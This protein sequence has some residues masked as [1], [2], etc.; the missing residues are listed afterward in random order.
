MAIAHQPFLEDFAREAEEIREK[1]TKDLLIAEKAEARSEKLAKAYKGLARGLHTLKGSAATLGLPEIARAAHELE[2]H[3]APLLKRQEPFPGAQADGFLKAIDGL[4]AAAQQAARPAPEVTPAQ[5]APQESVAAEPPA[6]SADG[7]EWRVGWKQ[8]APFTVEVERLR[9]SRIRLL[10]LRQRAAAMAGLQRDG[11]QASLLERALASEAASA[12]AMVEAL[13][14][15]L[16]DI[17]TVPAG[18]VI[19]PLQRTVRDLCRQSGKEARLS[20]VGGE[21]RVDRRILE[22][23]RGPLI[24]LVRNAVDHGIETPA[25]R[26]AGGKHGAGAIVV[27]VELQGNLVFLEMSDDGAGLDLKRV[28]E[29]AVAKG[30]LSAVEADRL[31]AQA[32]AALIFRSGFSTRSD[33]S[34][35]SGRGVGLDVVENEVRAL[36][37]RV[38]VSSVP[39]QGTRF[40]IMVPAKMGSAPFLRVRC[41]EHELA[42]PLLAVERIASV[43][44][45]QLRGK[46]EEAR[47]EHEG[48]I[49]K[50]RDL[51]GLLGLRQPIPFGD[52]QPLVFIRSEGR[53][54]AVLVDAILGE[55]E[56]TLTPL[57]AEL[58]A[59]PCYQGAI[60]RAGGDL[61]LVLRPDWLSGV[62]MPAPLAGRRALVV[63]DSL[64]ARALHRTSLESGGYTVHAVA[65]GR[66]ALE[67]MRHTMYDVIV[68][69]IGMDDLDGIDFT[70]LVR[71]EPSLRHIPILLVS[72][73]DD[74]RERDRGLE[75]G[76]DGF[77]SKRDCIGGR[78][79][80]EVAGV[81]ARRRR[82]A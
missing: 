70:K 11:G 57:P 66:Q 31:D 53:R 42:L 59:V 52:G 75:A 35:T 24:H 28:R 81:L 71:A 62:E 10:E 2:D 55:G 54:T 40:S 12:G 77:L 36:E 6:E 22:A 79:S 25:A 50:L 44:E 4:V 56:A 51:G 7:N 72:A 61:T 20:V 47:L 45:S 26:R 21:L 74:G 43:R 41:G 49:V 1:I 33:V 82:V 38:E 32:T 58:R 39:G 68:C 23:L 18:T 3:L 9:Q 15:A 27:R 78:L 73:L 14:G 29:A 64:T 63:D 30:L 5:P 69:D 60:T 8:L 17:C 19:E 80:A 48:E 34:D 67:Q 16:K 37:G 65:S 76:A 13:E 46:H